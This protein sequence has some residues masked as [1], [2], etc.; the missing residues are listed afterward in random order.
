MLMA[1]KMMRINKGTR[2]TIAEAKAQPRLV[3]EEI[4]RKAMKNRAECQR[5]QG[6]SVTWLS[7]KRVAAVRATGHV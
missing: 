3:N 4:S 7:H 5:K 2:R 1:G 6:I